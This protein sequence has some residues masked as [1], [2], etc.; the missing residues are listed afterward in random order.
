MMIIHESS[1]VVNG[2]LARTQIVHYTNKPSVKRIYENNSAVPTDV[3]K[4]TGRAPVGKVPIADIEHREVQMYRQHY[5][6]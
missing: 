2:K 4:F 1:E 6:C 5:N 3:V